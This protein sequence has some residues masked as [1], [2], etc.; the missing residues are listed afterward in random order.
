MFKQLNDPFFRPLWR[1]IVVV[2][3]TGAWALLE[4]SWGHPGWAAAFAAITAYCAFGF[5]LAFDPEG[6]DAD[7]N[8]ED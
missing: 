7:S 1:R 5:F 3:L 6:P 4:Y 2:L 8:E